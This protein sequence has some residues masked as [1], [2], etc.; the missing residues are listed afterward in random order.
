MD[1]KMADQ[2]LIVTESTPDV[3]VLN[4]GMQGAPGASG[5]GKN[6]A[7]FELY[8]SSLGATTSDLGLAPKVKLI[9]QSGEGVRLPLNSVNKVVV[10][11]IARNINNG[12]TFLSTSPET[13]SDTVMFIV[14]VGATRNDVTITNL[15]WG[16][17][18]YLN[19]QTS[20]TETHFGG[21]VSP[22]GVEYDGFSRLHYNSLTG[23][24]ELW[25]ASV[26]YSTFDELDGSMDWYANVHVTS[27]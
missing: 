26:N 22:P 5:L 18:P 8:G 9:T 19:F 23:E 25:A 24:L 2:L 17:E 4:E 10:S 12:V 6:S 14:R 15:F 1:I 3:V 16:P 27:F 20:A 13:S 7:L 21:L 11:V